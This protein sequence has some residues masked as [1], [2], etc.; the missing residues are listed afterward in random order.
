MNANDQARAARMTAVASRLTQRQRE[1]LMRFA[2]RME[3]LTDEDI[4]REEHFDWMRQAPRQTCVVCSTAAEAHSMAQVGQ[5]TRAWVAHVVNSKPPVATAA[6]KVVA[7]QQEREK[8]V[9]EIWR[10]I[11]QQEEE[12]RQRVS[13]AGVYLVSENPAPSPR[14]PSPYD[15]GTKSPEKRRRSIFDVTI[16]QE[17]KNG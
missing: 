11:H 9:A 7:E 4:G 12:K 5:C 16:P 3:S 1:T 13:G 6:E 15:V 8:R 17:E 2:R 14:K 10:S